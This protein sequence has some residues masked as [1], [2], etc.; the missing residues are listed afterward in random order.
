MSYWDIKSFLAEDQLT[1]F[2]FTED[3]EGMGFLDTS[4]GITGA[5]PA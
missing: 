2:R 4:K 1:L 3:A 5:V